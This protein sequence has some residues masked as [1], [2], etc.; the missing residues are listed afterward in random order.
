MKEMTLCYINEA[1]EQQK[2]DLTWELD[3]QGM[4]QVDIHRDKDGKDERVFSA[5]IQYDM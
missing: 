3:P 1:L 4:M 5:R 2:L